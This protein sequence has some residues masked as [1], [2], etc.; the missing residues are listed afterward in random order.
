MTVVRFSGKA[1]LRQAGKKAIDAWEV[2]T[3]NRSMNSKRK[4]SLAVGE[5]IAH[6]VGEGITV[7]LPVSDCDKYDLVIDDG[8]VFKRVQCKYSSGKESSGA[9]IVYLYTYGGYRKKTY[10]IKY[11][12]GDFDLLFVYCSNNEKYLIPAEKVIGKSKLSVGQK[13]WREYLI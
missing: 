11:K 13:S 1:Q 12:G 4:G 7:L 10:H 8:G 5:A 2:T 3:Y 9:Y 6:F